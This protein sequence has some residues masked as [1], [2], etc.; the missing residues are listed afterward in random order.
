[1][2]QLGRVLPGQL[3]GAQAWWVQL[4]GDLQD[5]NME[6]L[7]EVPTLMRSFEGRQAMQVHVDDMLITGN[8]DRTDQVLQP[9]RKKYVVK[10][11]GPFNKPGDEWEFLKRRFTIEE[12]GSI[13]VRPAA[14]FYID[15]YDLLERPRH[16]STPGPG[17]GDS[18][19]QVDDSEVLNYDDSSP[20]A[21]GRL[22]PRYPRLWSESSELKYSF[23]RGQ[24]VVTLSSGEAELVALS[25]AVS[26]GILIQ[27]A[28][29]FLVGCDACMVARTDSSVA[30][31]ISQ[32]AGVGRVRHLQTSCL[33]IQQWVSMRR[34]RVAAIPT[35]MNS[36]DAGTKILTAKR[37]QMLCGV[38]GNG[39]RVGTT[40]AQEDLHVSGLQ[41]RRALKM[42]QAVLAVQLQ[43]CANAGENGESS[44][45]EETFY[46]MRVIVE[47]I[48]EGIFDYV[49]ICIYYLQKHFDVFNG[50]YVVGGL[51]MILV[52]VVIYVIF[53]VQW[54]ITIDVQGGGRQ[55]GLEHGYGGPSTEGAI[56]KAAFEED[57]SPTT[58]TARTQPTTRTSASSST[59]RSVPATP[60]PKTSTTSERS[61][62]LDPSPSAHEASQEASSSGAQSIPEPPTAA[63]NECTARPTQQVQA[64]SRS[65]VGS[66][67]SQVQQAQRLRNPPSVATGASSS[68]AARGAAARGA[69]A[70]GAAVTSA[71]SSTEQAPRVVNTV[72]AHLEGLPGTF[73]VCYAP[74]RG[75]AYHRLTCSNVKG[76]AKRLIRCSLQHAV[77]RGLVAGRCCF[78]S[79]V[80]II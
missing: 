67:T 60:M 32:R 71:S 69:A 16:R 65:N 15:I 29:E 64:S 7:L 47:G 57:L 73:E 46:I 6:G 45:I 55:R 1:M 11:S 40:N 27:K 22:P 38:V 76:S 75:Y 58:R 4:Q 2:R 51:L 20:Q 74:S 35:Q 13:T 53:V 3:W 18:L 59:S 24:K 56:S 12:D 78:G 17:A 77:D 62:R 9:I 37:L 66:A 26:E 23:V 72:E 30:R 19:F 48:F 41:L 43:G 36:A 33:W 34:L 42:V 25:Q 63:Q 31:A 70:L 50:N 80:R 68:A 8:V 10:V 39:T 5:I 79:G 49:F 54:R 21:L 52:M 14:R 44:S 28:W 61:R